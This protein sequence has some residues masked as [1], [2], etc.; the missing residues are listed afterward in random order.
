[1]G[2]ARKA[3]RR[4]RG[5]SPGWQRAAA[6]CATLAGVNLPVGLHRGLRRPLPA[7]RFR[8]SFGRCLFSDHPCPLASLSRAVRLRGGNESEAFGRPAKSWPCRSAVKVRPP[9]CTTSQARTRYRC[10]QS[11]YRRPRAPVDVEADV[12]HLVAVHEVEA[13][14]SRGGCSPGDPSLQTQRNHPPNI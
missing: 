13:R 8:V 1:M 3:A 10:A 12:D 7:V 5:Q 11:Q 2:L 4:H 14:L 6:L 9:A